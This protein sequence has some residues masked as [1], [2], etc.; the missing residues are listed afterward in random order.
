MVRSVPCVPTPPVMRL[1]SVISLRLTRPV[2]GAVTRVNSTSSRA[3]S[4]AARD[5]C[6]DASAPRTAAARV[7][8]SSFEMASLLSRF[9][10][11][12]RFFLASSTRD[13]ASSRSACARRSWASYGR[14]S[15]VKSRSPFSTF[16]P[17]RKWTLWR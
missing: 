14:G 10:A 6:S 9:W 5:D 15:M 3:A 11:R 17:S 4:T 12:A 16:A 8:A 2:T 7:S 1:P 13:R